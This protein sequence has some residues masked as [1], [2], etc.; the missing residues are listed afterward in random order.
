VKEVRRLILEDA[1]ADLF[2]AKDR[3]TDNAGILPSQFSAPRRFQVL[4]QHRHALHQA[5]EH[6]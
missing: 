1:G 2:Q 6:Y 4:P 3:F 5:T